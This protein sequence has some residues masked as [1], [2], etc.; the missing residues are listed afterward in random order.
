MN[1]PARTADHDNL[2][3]ELEPLYDIETL[4]KDFSVLRRLSCDLLVFKALFTSI[5]ASLIP[6]VYLYCL[7][8]SELSSPW[9]Y[10]E[11]KTEDKP[12]WITLGT[13]LILTLPASSSALR[14]S[15]WRK[16]GCWRVDIAQALFP[17]FVCVTT[18]GCTLIA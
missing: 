17:Y 2:K 12:Y 9:P 4:Q 16:S 1:Y 7:I 3:A 10:W 14:L 6:S 15:G 18:S 13:V 11:V 5:V 8:D